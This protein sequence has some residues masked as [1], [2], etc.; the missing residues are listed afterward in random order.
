MTTIDPRRR[1]SRRAAVS[2]LATL[3]L[4]YA[5]RIPAVRALPALGSVSYGEV[6]KTAFD[7]PIYIADAM[8]YYTNAG[9]EL[10][11]VVIGGASKSA[12]ELAG[13]SLDLALTTTLELVEAVNG[14]APIVGVFTR[15]VGSPYVVVGAKGI[16]SIGQL[17]GK[18]LVVGGPNDNTRVYM[19][20]VLQHGG[21]KPED[22]SY[23]FAGNSPERFA[24]LLSGS[25]EAA[26]LAPPFSF[27]AEANGYPILDEVG[28]YYVGFP[29]NI[30]VANAAWAKSHSDQLVAFL[31]AH[32]RGV[33]YFYTPGNRDRCIQ[34]LVDAAHTTPDFASKSYDLFTR[35][36]MFSTTGVNGVQ[37]WGMVFDVLLRTN[38]IKRPIPALATY[39][40]P[41]YV[42]AAAAALKGRA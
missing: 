15:D 29:Q 22:Y 20:T 41:H 13:G 8:G 33:R 7:W 36:K 42:T 6:G 28:K 16:T 37:E 12:Q 27:Q 40:D 2:A 17:R 34:I 35:T 38:Q 4:T 3:A 21:L 30:I 19:D 11:L 31:K 18:T 32:L 24:A 26:I 25:V 9:I 14:G 10:D 23:I 5:A 1:P 39:V